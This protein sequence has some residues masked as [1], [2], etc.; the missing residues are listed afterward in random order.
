MTFTSNSCVVF[1]CILLSKMITVLHPLLTCSLSRYFIIVPAEFATR[2]GSWITSHLPQH[3]FVTL[4]SRQS[5]YTVLGVFGPRSQ[6]FL[7]GLT[8]TALDTTEYAVGMC[9]VGQ[10][11]KI[12]WICVATCTMLHNTAC[13]SA[14]QH[15]TVQHNTTHNTTQRNTT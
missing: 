12:L 14:T 4:R 13:H 1:R 2:A 9:K 15:N 7:Q 10:V 6:E 5:S 8:P 3:D 11:L